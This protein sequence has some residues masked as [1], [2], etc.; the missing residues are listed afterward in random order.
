MVSIK[1][2]AT[3][4]ISF[5]CRMH[6]ASLL[7]ALIVSLSLSSA[8]TR[9]NFLMI[10]LDDSGWTDFGCYGSDIHT[11]NI[12][13]VAKQGMRFTD[14]HSAAP[15]CSPSR[16]GLLT[17]RTPSRVGMYSYI[18]SNHPMHLPKTEVTIAHLLKQAG[19]HTGHFGKW[20]VAKLLSEQPQP[21]DLGFDYT[22]GTDNN[23]SPSH[24]NPGNFIRNGKPVG[25]TE[26][27]SCQLV[28]DET[29]GWFDQINVGNS[30]KPFLACV[31]F[32]E[33]HTP[34]ASPPTL[35]AKYR[36]LF[37]KLKKKE[38]TYY[39][40]IENVDIAVGRLMDKLNEL[41]I[42]DD[43]MVFITSDNGPLNAFSKQGLRGKKSHV[44][45]GGHR[46]PGIFRWPKRIKAGTV[47]HTPICGVDYLP[48]ICDI[49][50]VSLPS[51]RTIDGSSI[52]PLLQGK[53]FTRNNP[54]YWFFY[55]LLPST[56][57][58]DGDW[59]IIAN[60]DDA[61]RPKTHALIASDMQ[62]IKSS[63]KLQDF[64]LFNLKN[65]RAQEA[66]LSSAEPAVLERM[67]KKLLKFHRGVLND[68]PFWDV[69][70]DYAKG[71]KA[72]L[73]HSE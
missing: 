15:N 59:V 64:Q 19:Y 25:K 69:P 63:T 4:S 24:H 10:L 48:T 43:T 67:K 35:V 28:V 55:R 66:D 21:S 12:D 71:K 9:P 47:N 61:A 68:G 73:W 11:P 52:W 38:A 70:T 18:P 30:D 72:K 36:R 60:T 7:L 17:G 45:E 23:A 62:K 49:A 6:R 51:E 14:C 46:V 53:Q 27:Y 16:T 58:R 20:H 3:E 50:G 2:A 1:L 26:G 33:P 65:D 54:M 29:I 40:N 34:I 32:H 31:W 5:H 8:D 22:L 13:K 56:A 42:A 39:A 57:M 44:W 37:P 41:R